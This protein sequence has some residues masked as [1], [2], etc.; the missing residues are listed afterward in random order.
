MNRKIEKISESQLFIL[1][2][3]AVISAFGPIVTD[4]YLPAMP[5]MNK[6]FHTSTSMVQLSL[7]VSF[8]GLGIGQLLFGPVS[9]KYGRKKP[10]LVSLVLFLLSSIGCINAWDI[11][12]F[13]FF[14]LVQGFAGAGGIVI[15]KSVA[16]DLYRGELL[17]KFL[18]MLA[19]V[20]GMAPIIAPL[21][22]GA[23][24]KFTDWQGIFIV[25]LFLGGGIFLLALLH[26]ET[27]KPEKRLQGSILHTFSYFLPV[28]QNRDFMFYTLAL[29]FTMGTFFSYLSA[30]PFIF[31][32]VYHLSPLMYSVC[33]AINAF[34][35]IVGSQLVRKFRHS[36]NAAKTGVIGLFA[37]AAVQAVLLNTNAPVIAVESMFFCMTVFMGHVMPSTTALAL[38]LERKAAGN[39]SAVIG[40]S[41]FLCGSLVSPLVGLGN[42]TRSTSIAIFCCSVMCMFFVFKALKRNIRMIDES[43]DS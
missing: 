28:L 9:D 41:Q 8:L 31:Q 43:R 18:S 2:F 26:R 25:L 22:G 38:N 27:L 36:Q 37:S 24:L 29:S 39:A 42:V 34:G 15:A 13:N 5:S 14:R 40:F 17:T 10:L 16:V 30:S 4:L 3:L 11:H 35:F 12:S 19:A 7:T 1:F 32:E 33:F 21:A 20:Q 6:A 23:L